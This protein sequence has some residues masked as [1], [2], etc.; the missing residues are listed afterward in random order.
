VPHV[1]ATNGYRLDWDGSSVA[2]VSDHQQPAD[3]S[4]TIADSVLDLCAGVD[5]LIHDAQYTADQFAQKCDWGH[6]TIEYAVAVA[7]EAGVGRL[8]LFHHDPVHD[9]ATLDCLR[10]AAQRVAGSDLEVISAYEGL[11]IALS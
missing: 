8:A 9:D 3:G 7:R 4:F 11:T 1:G 10:H 2:Y 6:C 5:L